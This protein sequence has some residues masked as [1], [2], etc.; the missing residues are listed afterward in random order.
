[1]LNLT[2][3]QSISDELDFHDFSH[4]KLKEFEE[5][6]KSGTQYVVFGYVMSMVFYSFN[7]KSKIIVARSKSALFLKSLPYTLLTLLLGWWSLYGFMY[8]ITTLFKNLSGGTDVSPEIKS[9][10]QR[11]DSKYQYGIY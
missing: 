11:Q 1:M 2:V 8:T 6:L 3:H 4:V 5:S 9:Y 7:R 10:I